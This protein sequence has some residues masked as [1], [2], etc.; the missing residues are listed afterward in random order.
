VRLVDVLAR[1]QPA[2][3]AA[4]AR[5]GAVHKLGDRLANRGGAVAGH[6]PLDALGGLAARAEHRLVVAAALARAP[7]VAEDQIQH[8][9]VRP[10]ALDD[11]DRR[12]AHAF[13]EDLGRAPREA[14]RA[15][16]AHVAPVRPH[17]REDEEIIV[18]PQWI[19]HRHVV[20][21]R[22]AGIGL[23]VQEDVARVDVV[24]KLCAHRLHRPADRHDVQRMVLPLGHRDDLRL[25]IHEDAR[26]VLA[27]VEDRRVRGAHQR[28][29]HLAHDRD[30]GLAQH[31]ERDGIDHA[32][33]SR[34]KRMLP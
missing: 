18:C 27:L 7:H 3:R 31:L 21:V 13:L 1:A 2:D 28:H 33:R 15:H 12:D 14:A 34:S 8:G 29:A 20:E 6:E 30:E 25:A 26:K 22:A 17:D 10:A 16:P 19:D 4:H 11:L 24:P 5:F 32:V 9:L 23:V